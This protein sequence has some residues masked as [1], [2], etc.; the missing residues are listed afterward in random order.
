M[1][2]PFDCV[3]HG[4]LLPKL[5]FF[6]IN[7]K[8]LAL[9]HY[10]LGNRYFRTSICNNSDNKNTLSSWAKFRPGVPQGAVL[11]PLLFLLYINNLAKIKNETSAHIIFTDDTSILF[12]HSNLIDFNKNINTT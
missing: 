8:D 4:I 7:C 10:H 5:K 6:R 11:G 2:K 12:D 1:E 3:D 9:Y